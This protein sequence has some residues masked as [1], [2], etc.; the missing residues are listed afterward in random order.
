MINT[1]VF[2]KQN[3]PVI[4]RKA[5]NVAVGGQNGGDTIMIQK[6]EYLYMIIVLKCDVIRLCPLR[7]MFNGPL[8][9]LFTV[10][11]IVSYW[12]LLVSSYVTL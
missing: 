2:F 6:L 7:L 9:S 11:T 5:T 4:T 10:M 1:G 3:T 12:V 8:F